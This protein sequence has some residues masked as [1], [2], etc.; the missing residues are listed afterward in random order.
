MALDS[1]RSERQ[2]CEQL[3]D[4][5]LFRWFLDMRMEEPGFVP[6]VFTKNRQRLL[7]HEVGASPK[8]DDDDDNNK[9]DGRP[10][11]GPEVTTP[12]P[13]GWGACSAAC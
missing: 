3:D 9:W 13:G 4:N 10:P 5:L 11:I 12:A 8:D 7:D 1:V 6:T 2:F